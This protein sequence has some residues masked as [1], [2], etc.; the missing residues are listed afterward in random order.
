MPFYNAGSYLE[1]AVQSLL[2]QDDKN[3]RV[4]AC[5]DAS[6]DGCAKAIPTD[7]QRF[8]LRVNSQNLGGGKNF[9]DMLTEYC[10]ADDIVI[11]LDGDDWLCATDALSY[12]RR[13]YETY[14][15]WVMYG[16]FQTSSGAY[17]SSRSFPDRES[18]QSMRQRFVSSHVR[19]YRAGLYHR[20]SEQDPDYTCMKDDDGNWFR[21]AMDMAIMYP[22]LEL[23]GFER[24]RF[25]DR[26]L[27]T[28]NVENPLSLFRSEPDNE[29]A[30][31]RC[32]QNKPMF[33]RIESYF[34]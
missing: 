9:H 8:I 18:F 14:N 24:V 10:D 4:I 3:F 33:K 19:T 25:N 15:C 7:D 21:H 29:R 28:Y 26:I 17:G 34:P 12:I 22:V 30:A 6:T 27:Y 5:D 1:R 23:A 2:S 20:I 31:A 11:H 16:Q 32:I 13:F